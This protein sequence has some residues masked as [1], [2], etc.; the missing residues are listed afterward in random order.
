M[1]KHPIARQ[2]PSAEAAMVRG[3]QCG[4]S[5]AIALFVERGHR[6]VYSLACRLSHDPDLRQDW[7]HSVLLRLIEEMGKGAFVYRRPGGFWAWFRKRSYYL[8]LNH[9]NEHRSRGQMEQVDDGLD[10]I[11][12][13]TLSEADTGPA[14]ELERAELRRS[15]EDALAQIDNSHQRRALWLLLDQDLS[16]QEIAETMGAELNTVRSWIR[17]GRLTMRLFLA[18]RLEFDGLDEAVA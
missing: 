11:L 12:L 5:E 14:K 3:L 17:R 13:P 1:L 2:D 7:T 9:L 18:E 15:L 4:D 8:M 10:S 6:A 16:Y